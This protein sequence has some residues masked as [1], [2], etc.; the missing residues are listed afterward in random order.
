MLA[1]IIKNKGTKA[2][3]I[4]VTNISMDIPLSWATNDEKVFSQ[5][6]LF[7]VLIG[8]AMVSKTEAVVAKTRVA[9][10]VVSD[11]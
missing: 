4:P 5:K 8:T 7:D 2:A 3:S 6:D 11:N 9:E 10:G 1:N